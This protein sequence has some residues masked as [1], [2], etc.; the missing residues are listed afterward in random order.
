MTINL[1]GLQWSAFAAL[2]RSR[3]SSSAAVSRRFQDFLGGQG[4][5]EEGRTSGINRGDTLL[6]A[7]QDCGGML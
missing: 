3:W 4:V 7:N 5:I 1:T 2:W 6:K